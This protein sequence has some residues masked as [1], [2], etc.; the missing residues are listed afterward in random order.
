MG[1]HN[2]SVHF[3]AGRGAQIAGASQKW[4]I[5]KKDQIGTVFVCNANHHASLYSDELC[6]HEPMISIETCDLWWTCVSEWN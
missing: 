3:T 5:C 2:G 6:M 4:F 1:N